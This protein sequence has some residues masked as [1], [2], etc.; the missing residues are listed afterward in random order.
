MINIWRHCHVHDVNVLYNHTF[1]YRPQLILCTLRD[2]VVIEGV[3]ASHDCTMHIITELLVVT[4]VLWIVNKQKVKLNQTNKP[5][6]SEF[7]VKLKPTF[8]CSRATGHDQKNRE[9]SHSFLSRPL[10]IDHLRLRSI[11]TTTFCHFEFSSLI[12]YLILI[13]PP[14]LVEK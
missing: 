11:T 1:M 12:F 2:C 14:H 8:Q 10:L 3:D 7:I 13:Q 6:S 5:F 9:L 4:Y